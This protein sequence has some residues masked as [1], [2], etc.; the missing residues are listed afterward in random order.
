MS[1]IQLEVTIPTYNRIGSLRATIEALLPQ[2]TPEVAILIMDNASDVP[3]TYEALGIA[4]P[5][6]QARIRILRQPANVGGSA[7][8]VSCFLNATAP[9]LWLLSDDD[10]LEPDAVQTLLASISAHPDAIFYNFDFHGVRRQTRVTSG[11]AGLVDSFERWGDILLM[12]NC[13]FRVSSLLPWSRVGIHYAYSYAP[14]IA[15]LL[16]ALGREEKAFL[17]HTR[18]VS[19]NSGR[20]EGVKWSL[21]QMALTRMA[22]L[23]MPMPQ[24]VRVTLGHKIFADFGVMNYSFLFCLR[25][26]LKG[27]IAE[28]R[29]YYGKIAVE[30]LRFRSLSSRFVAAAMHFGL[31]FPKLVIILIRARYGQDALDRVVGADR[32]D[33]YW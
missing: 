3:V 13:V 10:L 17:S 7:N 12:S 5:S 26:A 11:L 16:H 21:M 32:A 8:I 20:E 27:Q 25:L 28:A 23:D 33:V 22:I 31:R 19:A 9:C 6:S 1:A 30:N 29:Y 15:M 4:D 2:L 24:S 18:I 14:H